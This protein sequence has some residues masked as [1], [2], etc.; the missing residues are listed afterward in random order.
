[1]FT[2]LAARVAFGAVFTGIVIGVR[3]VFIKSRKL[4]GPASPGWRKEDPREL[5]KLLDIGV[6]DS[7]AASDPVAV[8][9]PDVHKK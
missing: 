2:S 1:M 6:R 4:T 8:A 9:Q 7:M 3:H 5:D